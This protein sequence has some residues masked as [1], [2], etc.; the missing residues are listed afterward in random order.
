MV[1]KIEMQA[2]SRRDM[3][4]LSGAGAAAFVATSL[5]P[6]LAE[7]SVE[8]TAAAISKITG[9]KKASSGKITLELP[10]I[11]ENGNTVPVGFSVDSPMTADN[12][13]KSVTVFAEK[14]P[15][16][17]VAAFRLSPANG[18]AK[19]STRMRLARTQNVIAVAEMSDGGIYMAKTEVKVT[20][21]GCGG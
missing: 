18:K 8:E 13:V 2:V 20:I 1:M 6:G 17:E 14:N 11:A 3:L 4:K 5:M 9:G 12:Y 19:I 16:P 7:A 21:G 15:S 10:Q